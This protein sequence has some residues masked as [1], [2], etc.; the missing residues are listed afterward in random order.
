MGSIDIN[1]PPRHRPLLGSDV[2]VSGRGWP[3]EEGSLVTTGHTTASQHCTH[4]MQPL[5]AV[6]L[7]LGYIMGV[8]RVDLKILFRLFRGLLSRIRI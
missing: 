4:P 1:T 5:Q 3:G 2:T 6:M 7:S 8:L